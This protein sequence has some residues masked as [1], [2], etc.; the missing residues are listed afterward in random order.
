MRRRLIVRHRGRL[1]AALVILVAVSIGLLACVPRLPV[2]AGWYA[3]APLRWFVQAL[4]LH[5]PWRAP[6]VQVPTI[7]CTTDKDGDGLPDLDDIVQGARQEAGL[8]TVYRDGYYQGGYPPKG[9]GVCTDVIWRALK[10][11]GY[12]LKALVDKDI[13]ANPAAYPRVAGRPEPNIDFRRVPNLVSFFDR[14]ATK[15]ATEVIPGDAN[16]LAQWQRGDIVVFGNRMEHIGIISDRRRRDG[17]P[18]IIH[19]AGPWAA[20]EDRLL[21]LPWPITGHYRFPK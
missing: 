8:R 5:W 12:D 3:G 4:A 11:A 13:A 18:Y 7:P 1:A 2:E 15:L 6:I 21:S 19:N 10:N 9:E 14:F 17:V 20:E 16:N